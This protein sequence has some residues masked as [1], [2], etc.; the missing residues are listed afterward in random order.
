MSSP[1]NYFS[2]QYSEFL[3]GKTSLQ[4]KNKANQ[5][6]EVIP[7]LKL[8]LFQEYGPRGILA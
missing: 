3:A 7:G 2:S 5:V 6:C 4:N 8:F 1:I